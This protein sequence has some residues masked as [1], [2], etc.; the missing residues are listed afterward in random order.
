MLPRDH[1]A[2]GGADPPDATQRWQPR[3]VR[4]Y[5]YYDASKLV[6][7][8]DMLRAA[9]GHEDEMMAALVKKHGPEP[10]P[11][12]QAAAAGTPPAAYRR[13]LNAFYRHYNPAKL[14]EV[15]G[16]L[17]TYR[18]N[19]E[20]LFRVLEEKY[21]PAP[22]EVDHDTV[23]DEVASLL[24]EAKA[25][26]RRRQVQLVGILSAN[27]LTRL[28][29]RYYYLWLEFGWCAKNA[30]AVKDVVA[31]GKTGVGV[32]QQA[33]RE[34]RDQIAEL[35]AQLA[36]A[37]G[38][39]GGGVAS[40][41]PAAGQPSTTWS[42]ADAPPPLYASPPVNRGPSVHGHST[43][44]PPYPVVPQPLAQPAYAPPTHTGPHARFPGT[45]DVPPPHVRQ[46]HPSWGAAGTPP[47]LDYAAAAT[48]VVPPASRQTDVHVHIG[49]FGSAGTPYADPY[50]LGAGS[51]RS[52]GGGGGY[53]S[54]DGSTTR[55]RRSKRH[56]DGGSSWS[57]KLDYQ[58]KGAIVQG[59]VR[60]ITA[61]VVEQ[62][63]WHASQHHQQQPYY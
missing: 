17:Q 37:T 34:L 19:E 59:L 60:Q 43:P 54:H 9:A 25:L 30:Q 62:E 7:V 11:R 24:L 32:Q 27:H 22:V 10:D 40:L 41:E 16:L 55:K 61:G 35:Q 44:L 38:G 48:S 23:P 42:A 3:L 46:A 28:R 49:H 50:G 63:S 39:S 58:Q 57:Q 53:S 1:V 4:F 21:G 45:P 14:P 6:V 2:G 51:H 13:Q 12:S 31:E 56:G 36:A 26:K 15:T 29:R 5:K 33:N 20:Q 18:G 8:D 52:S 47:H